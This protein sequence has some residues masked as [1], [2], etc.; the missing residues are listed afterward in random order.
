MLNK[1]TTADARKK[2]SNIINRVAFGNESFV[3]T[4]RGEPIAALVSMKELKLLQELEDQIDI[5]DAWKAKAEPGEPIPWEELKK[6][7]ES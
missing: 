4:R 1:I 5:E 3:L 7:L 2:F 6:E